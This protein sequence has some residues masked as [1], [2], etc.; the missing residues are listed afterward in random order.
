MLSF[1]KIDVKLYVN[2]GFC[3]KPMLFMHINIGFRKKPML[4]LGFF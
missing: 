2:I 4:F 3:E 1:W